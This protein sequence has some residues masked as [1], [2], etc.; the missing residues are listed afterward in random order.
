MLFC[1]NSSYACDFPFRGDMKKKKFNNSQ[2]HKIKTIYIQ[3][4]TNRQ[5]YNKTGHDDVR[6]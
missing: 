1:Q 2:Y 5:E 3:G 6:D 4:T